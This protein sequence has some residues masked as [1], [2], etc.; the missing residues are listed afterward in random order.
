MHRVTI[1]G[2]REYMLSAKT[3]GSLD[4]Y[5]VVGLVGR[6]VVW[7]CWLNWVVHIFTTI[8]VVTTITAQK[9]THGCVWRLVGEGNT[10]EFADNG[11]Q[12]VIVDI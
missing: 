12:N 7:L 10:N 9:R 8:T 2:Q 11:A 6:L 4:W 1:N 3:V 5:S